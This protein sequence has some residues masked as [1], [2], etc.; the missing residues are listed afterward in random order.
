MSSSIKEI[1]AELAATEVV[2]TDAA[3]GGSEY[4]AVVMKLVES[5]EKPSVHNYSIMKNAVHLVNTYGRDFP[6]DIKSKMDIY[7]Y[8]ILKSQ[9]WQHQQPVSNVHHYYHEQKEGQDL[10][11]IV[12]QM[13]E[14][15][16]T[17]KSIIQNNSEEQSKSIDTVTNQQQRG[18]PEG[19]SAVK[20][21]TA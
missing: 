16:K 6:S 19:D 18:Q 15:I 5:G 2:A 9:Q 1:E 13:Q 14:D 10:F 17:I 20:Q 12:K 4:T 3:E 21:D 11:E 7:T 8:T